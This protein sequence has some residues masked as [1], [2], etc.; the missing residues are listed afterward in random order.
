MAFDYAEL[1]KEKLQKVKE[2]ETQLSVV[3]IAYDAKYKD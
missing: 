1:P 2:L 3:L